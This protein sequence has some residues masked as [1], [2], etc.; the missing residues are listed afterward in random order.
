MALPVKALA[1]DSV[2]IGDE[3]V[4]FRAMSRS[5]A[6]KLGNY[7]GKEDEAEIFILQCGTS[8]TDDEAKAFLDANDTATAGLLIEGILALSGL[9]PDTGKD[10]DPNKS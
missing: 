6:L 1:R 9:T 10:A 5:E 7:R 4:E 8:C 3:K 2:L